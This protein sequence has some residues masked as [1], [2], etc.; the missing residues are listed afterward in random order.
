MASWKDSLFRQ[1][2]EVFRNNCQ[3]PGNKHAGVSKSKCCLGFRKAK[4]RDKPPCGIG[5]QFIARPDQLGTISAPNRAGWYRDSGRL[6]KRSKLVTRTA[7]KVARECSTV[8]KNRERPPG[9]QLKNWWSVQ[10]GRSKRYIENVHHDGESGLGKLVS[11]YSVH[12]LKAQT[13]ENAS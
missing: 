12:Q 2:N 3:I 6:S 13:F 4:D 7:S 11:T 5:D 9:R 10:S 1:D 8:E